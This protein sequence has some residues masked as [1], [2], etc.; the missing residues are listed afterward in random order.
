MSVLPLCVVTLVVYE[1]HNQGSFILVAT[2]TYNA[3][4]K[5]HSCRI[6]EAL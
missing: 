5:V 3:K 6:F 2:V 4:T 1:A